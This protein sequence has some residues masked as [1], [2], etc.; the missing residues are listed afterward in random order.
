MTAVVLAPL[1][2]SRLAD[3]RWRRLARLL[4]RTQFGTGSG[5]DVVDWAVD[6]LVV[7]WESPA[8]EVLAGLEKPPNEFEVDRYVERALSELGVEMPRGPQVV[9]LYAVAIAGDILAGTISPY[10]GAREMFRICVA[11]NYPNELR[12]WVG[13]EDDYELARDGVYGRM[14]DIEKKIREAA[15]RL[16]GRV[17]DSVVKANALL[18]LGRV[19]RLDILLEALEVGMPADGIVY[20][21]GVAFA[22]DARAALSV[23]PAAPQAQ[24]RGDL[25][26][27][28]WP[29]PSSFHLPVSSGVLAVLRDL[30]KRHASPEVCDHLAVYRG[31]EIL[32]LAHD[33]GDG[34]L[35]VGRSL[36]DDAVEEMR[37][38][39]AREAAQRRSPPEGI[40]R[41][42]LRRLRRER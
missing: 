25:R 18:D 38:V 23:L 26:G 20:V 11:T 7:G 32:A 4:A 42:V 37:Q 28:L 27:T 5:S 22:D 36:P 14:D 30:E 41:R 3:G 13:L 34:V 9:N 24:R 1:D 12:A 21:E 29:S 2:S 35:L 39:V 10:D 8:L 33:A 31:Q 16:V 40:V 19:R 17:P 15:Q 6:A